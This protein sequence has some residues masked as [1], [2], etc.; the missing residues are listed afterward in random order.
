MGEETEAPPLFDPTVERDPFAQAVGDPGDAQH[1]IDSQGA[2]LGAVDARYRALVRNLPDCVV[3]VHDRD[4]RGV[5]IDGSVLQRV[6]Y[7]P[8]QFVGVTLEDLVGPSDYERLGPV[9]RAA[10]DG[11]PTSTEYQY[12]G[13]GAVYDIHVLPLRYEDGGEVHGVFTVARDVSDQK[14]VEREAAQRAAQQSA[15]A[16]LG[17]AALEGTPTE[18]LMDYAVETVSRTLGME[19]CELLELTDDREA[20]LLRAGVGWEDGLVRTAMVP[21]GSAYY[22]GFAW[23]AKG[24]VV[25]EDYASEARF[26]PTPVLRRHEGAATLGVVVGAKK[27]PYGVLAA[28]SRTPRSFRT[29]E[30]DFLQG[31]ANVLA[32]AI[33]RE[34]AED[35]M[36]HQALHDPLSGLPNRTLLLER[37]GHWLGR[38]ERGDK[39]A[40]VLFV[41]VDHFK[42]VNDALGHELGDRLLCTVA[43]RLRAALRPSDTVARIG[44]DEFVVLCEDIDSEHEALAVA[45][46]LSDA[47]EDPFKL[48]G[49]VHRV[50]ASIGVAT[51]KSGVT[52]DELMRDADAAMYRAKERGRARFELFREGMR[53]WSES[54]LTIE[55]E[56]REALEQGQLSNVYQPIVDPSDGGIVGFEALVRWHHPERG[57]VPPLDFIPMAE[58]TGLIVQLGHAVLLEACQEA[59][60]WPARSD[61]AELRISVNLSPRQLVDPGLVDSV[62]AVLRVTGLAPDRLSLEI[63]ESAFADD[64]ARAL[65]VLQ[66]LKELGVRLELDDF[67]TGYS[68]L[69]YV[70]MFPIDALKIDRSFVQ[71]LC[72]S[73][74]DAA[75]VAAVIS[76][77]RALGVNVVAEGVE[78][79]DQASVLSTLGCKLAQGFL[80]SRPVPAGML[81]ELVADA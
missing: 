22:A 21:V 80:F 34:A 29:D 5:S 28:H 4:L 51:W 60:R 41:D 19:L 1:P 42:V 17:V 73:P 27:R 74:E 33:A 8:D 26:T 64:P 77:G 66:R 30:V 38:A 39:T 55:A 53:A 18:R 68:S 32:E 35:R 3:S 25:V 78:S 49:R 44:G 46:R 7:D 9:Y 6:G 62:Q 23:G 15:V 16:A 2:G 45:K 70:R 75:I 20:L 48:A 50:T 58:Q 65:D 71:G 14:R 11:Q 40:A 37:L 47:F 12:K 56:L 76:M 36:R 81:A 10:L 67:G 61:G 24:P 79:E 43:R 31:I 63:T 52:A 57:M 54:W 69:T 72:Q 13:S 59:A